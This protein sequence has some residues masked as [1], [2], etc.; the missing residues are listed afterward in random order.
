MFIILLILNIVLALAFVASGGMKVARPPAALKSSGMLWVGD[1]SP[2]VV[3][4]IGAV[5]V[6][7]GIGLVLPLVTNIAP[8]LTPIAA[9]GLAIVMIGAVAV[10]V[11]R[12]EAFIPALVLAAL[13]VVSAVLG[14]VY[15]AR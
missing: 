12:K 2:A 3:K 9:V 10:H 6:L 13:S 11:R 8:V 5:E 7:G 1:F 4:L 14:F 15:L